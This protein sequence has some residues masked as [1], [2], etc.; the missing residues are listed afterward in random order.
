MR[1]SAYRTRTHIIVMGIF[2]CLTNILSGEYPSAEQKY[3]TLP[4]EHPPAEQEYNILSW[5]Y[6]PAEKHTL[7]SL[8]QFHLQKKNKTALR[9][10]HTPVEQNTNYEHYNCLPNKNIN[11]RHYKNFLQNR[12]TIC[13]HCNCLKSKEKKRSINMRTSIYRKIS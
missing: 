8:G 1:T 7:H 6:P 5:E 13:M 11:C 4:F 10:D 9:F 12:N 3:L 2:A